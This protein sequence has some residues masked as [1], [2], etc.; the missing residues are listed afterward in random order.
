M[1]KEFTF[2]NFQFLIKITEVNAVLMVLEFTVMHMSIIYISM[3]DLQL[4]FFCCLDEM[5]RSHYE[6]KSV[7][8]WCEK[9][10]PHALNH[11]ENMM[12]FK[13]PTFWIRLIKLDLFSSL[14]CWL[15]LIFIRLKVP[16]FSR[17][18]LKY[19]PLTFNAEP[20]LTCW[21]FLKPVQ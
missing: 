15:L 2:N 1:F 11:S 12:V 4:F 17:G 16:C 5:Q 9:C 6:L 10:G 13:F 3:I 19:Y 18:E 21:S 14:I 20:T 8:C 7:G